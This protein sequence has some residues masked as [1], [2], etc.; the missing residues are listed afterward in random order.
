[1]WRPGRTTHLIPTEI[2]DSL[3]VEESHPFS[4]K[5]ARRALEGAI[6]WQFRHIA[7]RLIVHLLLA[8]KLTTA[9][10]RQHFLST[11]KQRTVRVSVDSSDFR[12]FRRALIED[13]AR[14]FATF[15]LA[16]EKNP[17]V[18]GRQAWDQTETQRA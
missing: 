10:M 5:S 8:G 13:A 16:A 2:D 18:A 17:S 14:F 1:M 3:Q 7:N 4:I 6:V 9:E 11:Y 15:S 12:E